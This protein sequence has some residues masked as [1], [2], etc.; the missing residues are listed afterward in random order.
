MTANYIVSQSG[1]GLWVVSGMANSAT[2][3]LRGSSWCHIHWSWWGQLEGCLF[4]HFFLMEKS[5]IQTWLKSIINSHRNKEKKQRFLSWL[6][7]QK[8]P[9]IE[10]PLHYHL[11][12]SQFS[13]KII[14]LNE[15][16]CKEKKDQVLSKAHCWTA[17]VPFSFM[18]G[19]N[20]IFSKSFE[21]SIDSSGFYEPYK[22]SLYMSCPHWS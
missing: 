2:D 11:H 19:E 4:F 6:K 20:T 17:F 3:K 9:G 7:I 16:F 5:S 13:L 21:L 22:T 15:Q 8:C 18:Q 1:R 12:Y 10:M 14:L